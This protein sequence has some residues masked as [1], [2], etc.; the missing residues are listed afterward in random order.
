MKLSK[1]TLTI[2]KNF[3]G[4][5]TSLRLRPGNTILTCTES[6]S[7]VAKAVLEE[8]FDCDA[9]IYD[10]PQFL[11]AVSILDDP[12]IEF[13]TENIVLSDSKKTIKLPS[14]SIKVVKGPSRFPAINTPIVAFPFTTELHGRIVKA[15]SILS[16]PDFCIMGDGKDISVSVYNMA[17]ANG[18]NFTQKVGETDK[19]FKAIVKV[20]SL[21][22]VPS[23]YEAF[24]C[25][26]RMIVFQSQ[27]MDLIYC[28]GVLPES[29]FEW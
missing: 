16:A 28:D 9:G 13:T 18:S 29:N 27:S 10:L 4:I 17:N 21:R 15:S 5:S 26:K 23:D 20:D 24:L 8:S 25:D 22:F 2:L 7:L 1:N 6:Q 12:D 3:A 19:V 14:G 11:G